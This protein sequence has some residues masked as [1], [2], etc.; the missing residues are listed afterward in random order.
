MTS[1]LSQSSS[2]VL[3]SLRLN[4]ERSSE[5]ERRKGAVRIV[6]VLAEKKSQSRVGDSTDDSRLGARND[7]GGLRRTHATVFMARTD[8]EPRTARGMR[9]A[10]PWMPVEVR[11]RGEVVSV[12]RERVRSMDDSPLSGVAAGGARSETA[13]VGRDDT[14][15]ARSTTRTRDSRD[16]EPGG[17]RATRVLASRASLGRRN[18][19]PVARRRAGFSRAESVE[20]RETDAGRLRAVPGSATGCLPERRAEMR[21]G[22]ATPEM[23]EIAAILKTVVCVF[24][25]ISARGGRARRIAN[26]PL[27][28]EDSGEAR[29]RAF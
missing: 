16:L 9:T 4:R 29:H 5:R 12:L 22:R 27:A 11:R 2:K 8:T 26:K 19:R 24:M 6:R 7:G 25:P 17:D 10:L 28:E 3:D 1:A 21:A 15:H 18:D 20:N 13:R 23:Q 14:R